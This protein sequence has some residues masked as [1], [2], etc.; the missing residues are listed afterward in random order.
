MPRKAA[1]RRRQQIATA[2]PEYCRRKSPDVDALK[3]VEAASSKVADHVMYLLCT[4]LSSNPLNRKVSVVHLVLRTY[5]SP[6]DDSSITLPSRFAGADA[7]R[8]PQNLLTSRAADIIC[9]L[10]DLSPK[11]VS[12]LLI[13]PRR[14][15]RR[16]CSISRIHP[17]S[18]PTRD[19]ERAE[20]TRMAVDRGNRRGRRAG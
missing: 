9:R 16:T 12:V 17:H 18:I 15:R 14:K 1:W 6:H 2:R 5:P 7:D 20:E 10:I 11:G 19:S 4:R 13:L 3:L 8:L